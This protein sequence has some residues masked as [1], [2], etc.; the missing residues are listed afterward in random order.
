VTRRQVVWTT[1]PADQ[2]FAASKHLADALIMQPS[3]SECE[4][5]R[6]PCPGGRTR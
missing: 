1:C 5:P 4:R 3:L 2:P 6:A